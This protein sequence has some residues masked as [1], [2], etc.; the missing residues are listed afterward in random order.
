MGTAAPFVALSGSGV[1][2]CQSPDCDLPNPPKQ[3]WRYGSPQLAHPGTVEKPAQG[4]GVHQE[5]QFGS[6]RPVVGLWFGAQERL[7]DAWNDAG[8]VFTRENGRPHRPEYATGYFQALARTAG[9][10]AG[11]DPQKGDEADVPP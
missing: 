6:G 10:P 8:L 3:V 2:T 5:V 1:G 11:N 9:L 7:D 4:L